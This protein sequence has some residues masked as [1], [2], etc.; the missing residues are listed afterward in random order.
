MRVKAV[1]VDTHVWGV[2]GPPEL[3]E[4]KEVFRR[5]ILAYK[6]QEGRT[7]CFGDLFRS[8][9][10]KYTPRSGGRITRGRKQRWIPVAVEYLKEIS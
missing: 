6:S 1:Y 7:L 4:V 3:K 8:E 10:N 5:P 9:E 2:Y